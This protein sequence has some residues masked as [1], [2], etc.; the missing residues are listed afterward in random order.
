MLGF[1]D[2][3]TADDILF[4]LPRSYG[5]NQSYGNSKKATK[6]EREELL[7]IIQ[8]KKY[9]ESGTDIISLD[10]NDH[11]IIYLVDHSSDSELY[12]NLRE[13]G[14]GFGIRKTFEVNSITKDDIREITRNIAPFYDYSA[15]RISRLLQ[16]AGIGQ[17]NLFSTDIAAELQRIIDS[18]DEV[19]GEDR[20]NWPKGRSYGRYDNNNGERG[21]RT[22]G[23]IRQT[24]ELSLVERDSEGKPVR[25]QYPATPRVVSEARRQKAFAELNKRLRRGVRFGHKPVWPG[26]YWPLCGLQAGS[27]HKNRPSAWMAWAS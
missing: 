4:S 8:Q 24:T 3:E 1:E 2:E 11:K 5:R 13:G 10:T 9:L 18:N 15:A 22:E 23:S 27:I 19:Y 6:A 7:S 26:D 21:S 16:A 17:A 12:E 20:A 14:D 25:K